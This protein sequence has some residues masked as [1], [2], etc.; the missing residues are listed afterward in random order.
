MV[1]LATTYLGCR[2]ESPLVVAA[3][4]VSS[5]IDR[6]REAEERGAGALVI[7]TLFEEDARAVTAQEAALPAR[8]PAGPPISPHFQTLAS[9]VEREH[10]QWVE[11]ARQAVSF[12]L[13]GSLNALSFKTWLRYAQ[14]LVEAGCDALELNLYA[15]PTAA[16]LAGAAIEARLLVLVEE[17]VKTVRVP[18]S[19]KLSPFHT[20]IG[21]LVQG[22]VATGVRG[23]VL[24]NRFLQPDID[25][26]QETLDFT[27]TP[28][29]TRQDLRLPLRWTAL[30][31]GRV[32]TDLALSGG[33]HHGHD[34]A[35][36]LLAGATVA[37]TASALLIHGLP[38]LATMLGQLETWMQEA[39]HERLS[40]VRG[41]MSDLAVND[42]FAY[43]RAH[44]LRLLLRPDGDGSGQP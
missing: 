17:V 41:R 42:I 26:V 3:C 20:N 6:I 1:D 31:A 33:V 10:L 12:P 35:K 38:H 13:I 27:S 22:L 7:R 25:P 30:L 28:T 23:V 16:D 40:E 2:L 43:E 36:A 24:F 34:I 5:R 21:N 19:V 14:L 4:P 29:S 8:F 37:Q 18:V 9:P 44:Y 15:V 11:R 32:G 39:G